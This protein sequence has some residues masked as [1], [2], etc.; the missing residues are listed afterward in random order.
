MIKIYGTPR[1]TAFRCHWLIAEM[2]GIEYETVSVDFAKGENK[3]AEYLKLN[4]NGK[5]PTM[6]D[7]DV[8][9][10]ESM[11]ICYY[12]M[13]KY[14]ALQF[15]GTTALEHAQINQWN[16][17]SVIHLN[18]AFEPLVLQVYRKTPDSEATKNAKEVELPRYLG[19]LEAHLT[20]KQYMVME[21]FTLADITAMSVVRQ[22]AFINHDLSMYPSIQAWMARLSEREAYKK[23]SA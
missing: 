22:A 19:V 4:P 13:E 16:F 6:V 10:W 12:L 5:I 3:S 2:G 7:G 9:V 17:W 20:G 21:K 8:I 18:N 11:A 1:S 23:V 15:V 14:N